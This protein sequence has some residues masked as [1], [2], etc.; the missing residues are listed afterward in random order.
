MAGNVRHTLYRASANGLSSHTAILSVCLSV[1][2]SVAVL[3]CVLVWSELFSMFVHMFMY[4]WE[5]VHAHQHVRYVCV[6]IPIRM[7]GGMFAYMFVK[8]THMHTHERT[9]IHAHTHMHT[10]THTQRER[11]RDRERKRDILLPDEHSKESKPVALNL[12]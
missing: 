8:P 2:L 5:R 12:V 10:H 7:H 11:E 9:H 4:A 3:S 1:C 6:S